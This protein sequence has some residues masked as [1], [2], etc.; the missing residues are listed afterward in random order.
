MDTCGCRYRDMLYD[1]G[2]IRPEAGLDHVSIFTIRRTMGRLDYFKCVACQ[3]NWINKTLRTER[4]AYA[5]IMKE[6][7]P[8]A[9]DWWH[10]RFSDETHFGLGPMGKLMIIRKSGEQYCLNCI[11]ETCQSDRHRESSEAQKAQP[12]QP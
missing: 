1:L 7:Y 6:R 3:R 10:V 5:E 8:K 11:Q 4:V 2:G 12:G 9:H